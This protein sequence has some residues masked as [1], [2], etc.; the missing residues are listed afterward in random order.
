[1]ARLNTNDELIK[2]LVSVEMFLPQTT[3]PFD[4]TTA[5]STAKGASVI[6]VP[7][8]TNAQNADPVFILGANFHEINAING[9]PATSM[10][11]LYKTAAIHPAGTRVLEAVKHSLGR[12]EANGFALSLSQSETII[13]AADVE[14]PIQ[15][16][17]GVR[18]QSFSFALLG[19]NAQNLLNAMGES[20]NET[21]ART[22]ADPLIA[23]S[24]DPNGG[25]IT[26]VGFRATFLRF[27]GATVTFDVTNCSLA[28]QGEIRMGA[29]SGTSSIQFAGKYSYLTRREW[30]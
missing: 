10:P 7:A 5:G 25:L 2:R 12:V 3:S 9:T 6:V 19:A 29:R 13:E 11:L 26:T 18:E 17:K 20:D 28:P 27:D 8:I 14:V 24:G 15:T 22:A 30:V 23:T 21:G 16:I 1:M 4:Q